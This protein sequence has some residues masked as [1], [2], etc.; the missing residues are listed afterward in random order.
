M[1]KEI[2]NTEITSELEGTEK[3]KKLIEVKWFTKD[4]KKHMILE[5][6]KQYVRLV[7]ILKIV[8]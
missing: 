4:M 6:S 3:E 2:L 7:M 1:S 5:N 8:L